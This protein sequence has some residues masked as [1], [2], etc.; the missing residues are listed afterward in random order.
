[1]IYFESVIV[2]ENEIVYTLSLFN[3]TFVFG[4]EFREMIQKDLFIYHI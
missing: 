2:G 3:F 4:T 1:M